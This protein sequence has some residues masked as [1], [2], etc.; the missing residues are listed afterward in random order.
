MGS[1][2]WKGRTKSNRRRHLLCYYHRFNDARHE[3]H[4]NHHK[5]KGIRGTRYS[6]HHHIS[7]RL[8]RLRIWGSKSWRQ[9]LHKQAY[10]EIQAIPFNEKICLRQKGRRASPYHTDSYHIFSRQTDTGRGRQWPKPRDSVW[11]AA[12]NPCRSRDSLR[13]TRSRW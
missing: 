4:R 8:F 10:H 12:R 2:R 7:I 9:R 6:D 1:F 13:R 3:R 11:I 5:N